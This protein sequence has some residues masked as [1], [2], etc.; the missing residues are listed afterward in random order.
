ILLPERATLYAKCDRRFSQMLETGAVDEVRALLARKLA[1][2]LPVMRAIG[3]AEIAGWLNQEI[4]MAEAIARGAQATRNYAKRQ[5][6]WFNR[7]PPEDWTRSAPE[8]VSINI[9]FEILF[10]TMRLT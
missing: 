8:S 4:D 1:P 3:V 2:N 7:Q 5:Y 10:R 9:N 6:T